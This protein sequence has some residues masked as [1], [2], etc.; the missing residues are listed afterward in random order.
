MPKAERQLPRATYEDLRR[1][2]PEKVAELVEGELI[3]TPRPATPHAL[4]AS[5]LGGE[6]IGAFDRLPGGGGGPGGWFIL[7]EPELHFGEDVLVPDV[8]GWRRERM[9]RLPNAPFLTLAPDWLCEVTSPS[10]RAFDRVRK[11][12]IYAR[13]KV[14]HVWLL[15]PIDRFLEIFRLEGQRFVLASSHGGATNIRAE[16]FQDLEIDLGRFWLEEG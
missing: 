8:A 12:P 5:R 11:M 6:L 1:V 10:T 15:D 13:E 16:P 9:P 2:P 3:V 7:H 14:G 4:A